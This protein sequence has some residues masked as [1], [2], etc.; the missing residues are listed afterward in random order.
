MHYTELHYAKLNRTTLNSTALNCTTLNS[1]TLNCTTL[2]WISLS[3]ATLDCTT[4]SCTTLKRTTLNCIT[5]HSTRLNGT[6]RASLQYS[7]YNTVTKRNTRPQQD[8]EFGTNFTQT[9]LFWRKK[10]PQK[11]SVIYYFLFQEAKL[12]Y[13][14]NCVSPVLIHWTNNFK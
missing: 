1:F 3:Y 9:Q 11:Y 8:M 13:L 5:L 14:C 4:L 7:T 10:R 6:S 2:N 12:F